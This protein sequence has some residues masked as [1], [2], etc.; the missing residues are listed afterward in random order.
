M[1]GWTGSGGKQT[2]FAPN[3]R[4]TEWKVGRK[5]PSAGTGPT[6]AHDGTHFV[7]LE[8][9]SGKAGDRSYLVSP[10]LSASVG[11]MQFWYHMYGAT[12]GTLSVDAQ[13]RG[14]SWVTVWSKT[15]QQ[16]AHQSSPWLSSGVVRLPGATTRV[17]LMGTK[18][19]VNSRTRIGYMGDMAVDSVQFFKAATRS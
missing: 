15:G 3:S 18:G 17:R 13:I 2:L 12:M 14:A 10:T 11:T 5:T 1:C 8:T 16:Q 9:S 4:Q 7:F 19:K 6:K